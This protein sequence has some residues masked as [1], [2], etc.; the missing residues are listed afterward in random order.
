V[1][2][3]RRG[4]SVLT[5]FILI[6]SG[7]GLLINFDI[8]SENAAAS[9]KIGNITSDETWNGD[10]FI[11]GNVNIQAGVTVTKVTI[12]PGTTVQFNGSYSI[13][14]ESGCSLDAWGTSAAPIIFK[15]QLGRWDSIK[16]QQKAFANFTHCQF[17][18]S[19]NGISLSGNS[20]RTYMANCSFND[21]GNYYFS[22]ADS[23]V[24]IISTSFEGNAFEKSGN[25][26]TNMNR[27]DILDDQSELFIEY[28]VEIEAENGYS[29]KLKDINTQLQPGSGTNTNKSDVYQ[30]KTDETGTYKMG[31]AP[32]LRI[33]GVSPNH[34]YDF[35][36]TKKVD[37]WDKYDNTAKEEIG[38]SRQVYNIDNASNIKNSNS[39]K[40]ELKFVFDYPPKIETDIVTKI[41][42]RED[43]VFTKKF[44]FHD[45]DDFKLRIQDPTIKNK[46]DNIT[47]TIKDQNGKDIYDTGVP[48]NTTRDKWIKW[49]NASNG[50][51]TFGRLEFYRTV[52]SP[53]TVPGP[54]DYKAKVTEE[55]NIT[56]SDPL[57]NSTWTGPIEVEYQNIPDKPDIYI[58]PTVGVIEDVDRFIPIAISDDD[59]ATG[60]IEVTSDFL[61]VTYQKSNSSLKLNFPNEFGKEGDQ[62][63][64]NITATDNCNYILDGSPII[65]EV[66]QQFN[67]IF[68]STPDEP[69]IVGTIPD[70]IGNETDWVSALDLSN[71]WSDPDKGENEKTLK[72]FVTG[73]D[74]TYFEV[75][76]EN[77]SANTPLVF[78]LKS[79]LELGGARNPKTVEDDI[80]IWL[81]DKDG[82][83]DSQN[84][85]LKLFSTN[86]QPSLHKLD[87]SGKK[88]SVTPESGDTELYFRFL[89]EYKDYDGELGDEPEYVRVVID[90][91]SYD[92]IETNPADDDYRDGKKYHYET[93][94]S[95]GTHSHYFIC[96]DTGTIARHPDAPN[97][98][99]LP[100][101]ES[102]MFIEEFTS[103]DGNIVTRLAFG[104]TDGEA[105]ILSVP[106]P[107]ISHDENK[108]DMNEYF[109]V[110][111][112]DMS[113]LMWAD[114]TIQFGTN[115]KNYDSK[116]LRKDDMQ[117]A[118]VNGS[119]WM[120]IITSTVKK[121][122]YL[123]KCNITP[124]PS[125]GY[126]KLFQDILSSSN[127]PVFTVIGWLDADGDGYFNDEDAFPFDLAARYDRDGDGSPGD[128]EWVPGKN[129]KDST[130]SPKLH[131][132]KFPDDPAASVDDD[133][134][135]YPDA[136]NPGQIQENSTSVPKLELD[137]FPDNENANIDTDGDNQPDGDIFNS[138]NWMDTDDDDDGM[139]DHWE[140]KWRD[141]ATDE[142]LSDTFDPKD[143]SDASKDYD[144]DGRD[145]LQ[146][147]KDD[148]N[149]FKKDSEDGVLGEESLLFIII[150]VVVIIIVVLAVVFVM[151][152]RKASKEEMPRGMGVAPPPDE[153][154]AIPPVPETMEGE[155]EAEPEPILG[156]EPYAGIPEGEG[157][158]GLEESY[159]AP[160]E[161]EDEVAGEMEGE[162]GEQQPPEQ[163]QLEIEEETAPAEPEGAQEQEQEQV[164]EQELQYTC[165]N[166]NTPVTPDLAA[167]PG[168]QTPLTFE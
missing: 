6:I 36:Y 163:E 124:T 28:F 97:V 132:D 126:D 112:Q 107:G 130:S 99:D 8:G 154:E 66:T 21:T 61:Y 121:N 89:I 91:T 168:C 98:L 14:V 155:G 37:V 17:Q 156:E 31:R 128:T 125:Y 131:E 43:K 111:T 106:S 50:D 19:N 94:L 15:I 53:F 138:Q 25:I 150:I 22:L 46:F 85:K 137:M 118:Y 114:F 62:Q 145:N 110:S 45:N 29:T 88:M 68:H 104:G 75:S 58:T 71:Y 144:D 139:L 109:K 24:N 158:V 81:A 80:T 103:N 82:L 55:I 166:C 86:L 151:R 122:N 120:P 162:I 12:N 54:D 140:I 5:V 73:V 153:A 165:P 51:S 26:S 135:E 27:I 90:N 34:K 18:S 148:T 147:Y 76:G 13:T 141:H 105:Q 78:N 63:L 32:A 160:E 33:Y 164:Q 143:P 134:D 49:T 47:I 44:I 115:F 161:G 11:D 38:I 127:S 16:I 136:W 40:I 133:N 48:G 30:G 100:V 116:W 52:E 102:K 79:N 77:V 92:M 41:T 74:T 35:D 159:E 65:N 20:Y 10:V 108:G 93:K 119:N 157:E 9:N 39:L 59:N 7:L 83:T 23:D 129:A 70:M 101:V 142:G 57:G 152:K 69:I 56:I 84:I 72:W 2:F 67:V 87:V 117:L 167:C 146:E 60:D 1:I 95:Q 123:L 113:S 64:V 42:G 3:V 96:S 4:I 149:P